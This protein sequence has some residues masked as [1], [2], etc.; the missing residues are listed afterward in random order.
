MARDAFRFG[1]PLRVRWSEVDAQGI[2]FNP[3][4]LTYFDVAVTD[5]WRAVGCPYPAA[6]LACGVD[7]FAVK[8]T[9][10]FRRSARFD[11]ELDVLVRTARLGRT[12]LRLAFEI[13]RR[14]PDPAEQ[15]VSGELVYVTAS[16]DTREPRPIPEALR[17]AIIAYE[18]VRPEE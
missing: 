6:F 1:S 16:A 11:D 18:P 13:H 5:Y 14:A 15:L 9:L 2:V 12:S 8:A 4:Y 3:H 17:A 7:T 10:N